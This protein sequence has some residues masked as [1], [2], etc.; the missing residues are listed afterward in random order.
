M[1]HIYDVTVATD[2][3]DERRVVKT[4]KEARAFVKKHDAGGTYWIERVEIGKLS[5]DLL[6]EVI[7]S[8]G[9]SYA[10]SSEVVEERKIG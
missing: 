6:C 2:A 10:V 8:N 1:S 7:N 4:L 3:G 5:L 9:G